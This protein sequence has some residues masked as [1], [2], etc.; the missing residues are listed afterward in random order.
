MLDLA[1]ALMDFFVAYPLPS[2][3]SA[4]IPY[5]YCALSKILPWT[6]SLLSAIC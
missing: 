6:A 4:V 2:A 1:M 5:N 3:S